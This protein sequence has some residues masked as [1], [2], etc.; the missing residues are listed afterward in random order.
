[1]DFAA[2]GAARQ[3]RAVATMRILVIDMPGIMLGI[4]E[5]TIASEPDLQ[6]LQAR[7]HAEP[8]VVIIGTPKSDDPDAAEAALARWPRCRVLMVAT[9][10]RH[11]VMY[12]LRP[13]RRELG[14]LSPA[15]LVSAIRSRRPPDGH[16]T[17]NGG[18][19]R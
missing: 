15:D 5:D 13:L 8:D 4:I 1:M 7:S 2:L 12:E 3:S 16:L 18:G 10:G 6:L 9:S 17:H 19:G 14:E 11:A